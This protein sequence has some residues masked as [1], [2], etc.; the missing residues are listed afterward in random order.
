VKRLTEEIANDPEFKKM[1]R[2]REMAS[3]IV[4]DKAPADLLAAAHEAVDSLEMALCCGEPPSLGG[5]PGCT[6][7]GADCCL[8]HDSA[9]EAHA[10]ID[11]AVRAAIQAARQE[12]ASQAHTMNCMCWKDRAAAAGPGRDDHQDE[13]CVAFRERTGRE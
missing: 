13:N 8:F 3:E 2:R 5:H 1:V 11:R 9:K 4:P 10:V 6:C 7:E 12:V